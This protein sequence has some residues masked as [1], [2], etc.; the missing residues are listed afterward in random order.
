MYFISIFIVLV[1]SSSRSYVG[2]YPRDLRFGK[3]VDFKE[4]LKDKILNTYTASQD[5][6]SYTTFLKHFGEFTVAKIDT[7]EVS[8]SEYIIEEL[9]NLRMSIALCVRIVVAST[10]QKSLQFDRAIERSHDHG[11]FTGV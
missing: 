1:I 8:G 9:K 7:K 6:P 2:I 3:I 11:I 5:N 10:E 4:K